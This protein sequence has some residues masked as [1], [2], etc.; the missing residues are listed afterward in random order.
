MSWN[1]FDDAMDRGPVSAAWVMAKFAFVCFTFGILVFTG[2]VLVGAV[3]NPFIQAGRITNKTMNADN[4][5]H[6]YEWFKQTY[7]DIQAMEKKIGLSLLAIDD[8]E[9]SA[10]D[11]KDWAREDKI[12]HARLSAIKLGIENQLA[13]VIAK[14]NARSKMAN[15]SIFKAGD[16][17]LPEKIQL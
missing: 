2:L 6:N 8:F 10:G 3:A 1:K 13:D 9:R 12:E 11:R 5:I 17:E 15:R 14:Y 7:E 4:I 16:T